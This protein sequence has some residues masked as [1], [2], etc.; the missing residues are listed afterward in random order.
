MKTN[1][2]RVWLELF[3]PIAARKRLP[4]VIMVAVVLTIM[5]GVVSTLLDGF[6]IGIIVL[7]IFCIL[8]TPVVLFAA[9]QV[10]RRIW[11]EN[12]VLSERRLGTRNIDLRVASKLELLITDLRGVRVINLL[13]AENNKRRAISVP[14]A[15]Y[16]VFGA[17]EL[18]VLPLR[19]LADALAS[20]GEADG[21]VLSE[22]LIA[23]LRAEARGEAAQGRPLYQL[24]SAV[25][26]GRAAQRIHPGS[27]SQFVAALD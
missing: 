15:G 24:A 19:R 22:L 4:R 17:K 1:P 26:G 16:A 6:Q 3:D 5:L 21:L 8:A 11:I 7:I 10:R 18:E 13:C 9:G 23:Q 12:N 2:E 25:P 27:V 20:S 14:L